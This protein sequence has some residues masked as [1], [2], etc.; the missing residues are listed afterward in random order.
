MRIFNFK[1][2]DGVVDLTKRKLPVQNKK[3]QETLV[4]QEGYVDL[5]NT[6]KENN[7]DSGGLLSF[8]SDSSN[9]NVDSSNSLPISQKQENSEDINKM[10][11]RVT[12]AIETN[13]NELYRLM[14]RIEL[15]ERKMER[16]DNRGF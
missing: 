12:S 5:S 7:E 6:K 2:R 14:Q 3:K 13:S 8:F 4:S 9:N 16:F 15:L 11:K 10:L 1:K